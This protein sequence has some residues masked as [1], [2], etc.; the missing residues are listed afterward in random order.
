MK[1]IKQSSS[2]KKD[3]KRATKRGKNLQK[4][5]HIIEKLLHGKELESKNHPHRL[6]GNYLDKWECH[7]EPDWL[8]IYEFADDTLILY[9]M[10]SHADLFA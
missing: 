9:R 7:I 6:T 2:F 1:K 3:I 5:Y 4:L 10:G 8:L